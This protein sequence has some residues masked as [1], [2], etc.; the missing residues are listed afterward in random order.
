MYVT[1]ESDSLC[2][3]TQIILFSNFPFFLEKF[4]LN[5]FFK[6]LNKPKKLRTCQNNVGSLIMKDAALKC[7]PV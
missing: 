7:L 1:I 3:Q 4:S 5:E 6:D 2:L